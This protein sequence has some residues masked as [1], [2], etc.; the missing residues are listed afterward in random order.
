M[1]KKITCWEIW[2]NKNLSMGSTNLVREIVKTTCNKIRENMFYYYYQNNT[3]SLHISTSFYKSIVSFG[4][5]L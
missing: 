5:K 3:A 2:T 1:I 4:T